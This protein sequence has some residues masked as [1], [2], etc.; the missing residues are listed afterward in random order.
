MK[1]F[2][3]RTS[4]IDLPALLPCAV[5][6]F[7][8]Q[9]VSGFEQS[10]YALF[11]LSESAEIAAAKDGRLTLDPKIL[12]SSKN[13]SA[14]QAQAAKTK[15]NPEFDFTSKNLNTDTGGF[16]SSFSDFGSEPSEPEK[17]EPFDFDLF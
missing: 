9:A 14:D 3:Q 6:L 16:G 4:R 2:K 5:L 7:G 15:S 1:P 11:Q 8:S 17:T 10:N 12:E 13:A